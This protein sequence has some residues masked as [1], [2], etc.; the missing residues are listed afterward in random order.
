[1]LEKWGDAAGD[2]DEQRMRAM[3]RELVNLARK[4][5]GVEGFRLQHES[6]R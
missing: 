6:S 5:L 2:A 3:Y 4:E 1:M